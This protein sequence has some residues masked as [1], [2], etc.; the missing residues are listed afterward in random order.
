AASCASRGRSTRC[1][2]TP[3]TSTRGASSPR[4]RASPSPSRSASR[5]GGAMLVDA[6]ELNE[7]V[8][9]FDDHGYV[10][11][12]GL[13]SREEA[14]ALYAAFDEFP[15]T[16]VDRVGRNFYTERVLCQDWRF[17]EALT[18]PRLVEALRECVGD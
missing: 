2:Q 6:S 10:V 1:S 4:R 17:V 5:K 11:I 7:A 15:S 13:L 18:K 12:P 8:S 3:S 9:G 14:Q 16:H